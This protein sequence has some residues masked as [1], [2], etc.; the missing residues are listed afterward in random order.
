VAACE[1]LAAI[2]DAAN[3]NHA[4]RIE[5]LPLVGHARSDCTVSQLRVNIVTDGY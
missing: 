4:M 2:A 5:C 1:K 3:K